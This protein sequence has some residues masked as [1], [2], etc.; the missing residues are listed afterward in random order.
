MEG[1]IVVKKIKKDEAR[2]IA[3]NMLKV[4][5]EDRSSLSNIYLVDS[6]KELPLQEL[7]QWNSCFLWMNQHRPRS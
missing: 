3:I 1:L 2:E 5:M 6:N 4:G 7:W